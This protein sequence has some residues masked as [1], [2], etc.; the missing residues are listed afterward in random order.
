MKKKFK[1]YLFIFLVS[2]I[3]P[4]FAFAKI[5]VVTT[6]SPIAS[7]AAMVG[8]DKVNVSTIASNNGCPHHYS[9]KPSDLKKTE[10]ADFLIYVNE[11][12][13]S[14]GLPLINKFE[15]EKIK[16]STLDGIKIIDRNFHLWLLPENA[17]IIM[18]ALCNKFSKFSPDDSSYFE[19]RLNHY[20]TIL[21]E[22]DQRRKLIDGTKIV[23]LSD[24]ADYLFSGI[25]NARK[26]YEYSDFSSIKF[27][28][29][30]KRLSGGNKFFII[31][32]DQNIEKYESLTGK[33]K[34]IILET[35]N[36]QFKEEIDDLYIEE[37][38]KILSI[39]KKTQQN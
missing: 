15:K 11:R 18:K 37:Y 27:S 35:E 16:I 23:I 3:F 32:S 39:L 2:I 33:D 8:G 13:D 5:N 22:I 31:S 26:I 38:E 30:I 1:I 28:Q 6:I 20:V 7:L 19:N 4:I 36:W 12:F 24:S 21:K 14:F 25:D 34:L 10:S 9:L 29:K 17:I